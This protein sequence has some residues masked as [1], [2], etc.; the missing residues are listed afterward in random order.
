MSSGG[1][2]QIENQTNGKRYIG[3][4]VNVQRRQANHLSALRH[5]RHKNPHLQ[6]AFKKYGEEAFAFTIL[7]QVEDSAQLIPREQYY[8][9]TLNPE[10]NIALTAGSNLGRRCSMETLKRMSDAQKGKHLSAETRKKI[11][12]AHIGVRLSEEHRRNI[13]EAKKGTHPTAE[14]RNKMSEAQ[15]GKSL[16]EEHRRKISEAERG[17]HVTEETRRRISIAQKAR[18]G[19]I[20][21]EEQ[22][23]SGG[24][25]CG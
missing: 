12:E 11:S 19:R 13:S 18:W 20:H 3:S 6:A 21:A 17:K 1:I 23:E 5:R 9:D 7:E 24:A 4:S 8:L 16:S 10:Y 14:T 15:K 22:Q 2:Y 25:E